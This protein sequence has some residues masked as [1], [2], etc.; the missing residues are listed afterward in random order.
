MKVENH[1][2]ILDGEALSVGDVILNIEAYIKKIFRK[3]Y[4]I[5]LAILLGLGIGY[6]QF[7]KEDVK[8]VSKVKFIINED[9]GGGLS[10]VSGLL[11]SFGIGGGSGGGLN[12]K[13]VISLLESHMSARKLIGL[14]DGYQDADTSIILALKNTK[15]YQD[16]FN[17][18]SEDGPISK[19]VLEKLLVELVVGTDTKVGVL[20]GSW[21]DEDKTITISSNSTDESLSFRLSQLAYNYLEDFYANETKLPQRQT[22]ELL[23]SKSDSIGRRIQYLSNQLAKF[24]D[25]RNGLLLKSQTLKREALSR[26]LSISTFAYSKVLENKA[27][28]EFS[29][30]TNQTKFKKIDESYLPLNQDQPSLLKSLLT[31]GILGGVLS[32]VLI[33]IVILYLDA[34]K[35]AKINNSKQT[36]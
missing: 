22:F 5:V 12:P 4:W 23:E 8:Y 15:E 19:S 25:S 17:K 24:D 30:S 14:S 7:S 13:T 16:G 6:F 33:L 27:I 10:Q 21:D 20:S 3:W 31:F 36:Q 11:S 35:S 34:T 26:E 18:L 28:A 9:S 29:M 1:T 2:E 32:S